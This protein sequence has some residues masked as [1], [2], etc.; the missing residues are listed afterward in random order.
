MI[1]VSIG[2]RSLASSGKADA[3]A[4]DDGASENDVAGSSKRPVDA[5]KGRPSSSK[6]AAW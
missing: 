5:C 2:S 4:V 6:L 1:G 3:S